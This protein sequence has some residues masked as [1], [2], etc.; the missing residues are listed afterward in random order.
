MNVPKNFWGY[1][2]SNRHKACGATTDTERVY[3]D[4]G[5]PSA[6]AGYTERRKTRIKVRMVDLQVVTAEGG[7]GGYSQIRRQQNRAWDSFDNISLYTGG[8]KEMSSIL[9][10]Q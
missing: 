8:Y 5:H 9:T 4:G 2:T 1:F 6:Q 10:D 7:R 3:I